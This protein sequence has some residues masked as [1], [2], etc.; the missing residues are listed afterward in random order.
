MIES[1]L[2]LAGIDELARH[3]SSVAKSIVKRCAIFGIAALFA[4]A[5]IGFFLSSVWLAVAAEQGAIMA[6]VWVGGGLFVIALLFVLIGMNVGHV[7]KYSR[8]SLAAAPN[9]VQAATELLAQVE[10]Q[11][12][13][14]K[15]SGL[16]A[17]ATAVALG[18]IASRFMRR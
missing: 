18:F 5:A 12:K 15:G 16:Q 2:A 14:K 8:Q 1:L 10:R 17:A 9:P 11:F 4:I 7:P 6:S 13:G 3:S